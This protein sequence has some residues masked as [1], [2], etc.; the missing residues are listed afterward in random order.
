MQWMDT[1]G[2]TS[3]DQILCYFLFDF[4]FF[5]YKEKKVKELR[6]FEGNSDKM[7]RFYLEWV[8]KCRSSGIIANEVF[9]DL[10]RHLKNTC[11]KTIFAYLVEDVD[12]LK[13]Y[14]ELILFLETKIANI[15]LPDLKVISLNQLTSTPYH[16][17]NF[18]E[19]KTVM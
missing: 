6:Q 17:K 1:E 10:I 5:E 12:D 15:E 9:P 4:D 8:K 7:Q 2:L 14:N 18:A 13:N 19:H 16:K 3:Y 11:S